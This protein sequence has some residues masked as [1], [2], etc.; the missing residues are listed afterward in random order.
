MAPL[1]SE[2]ISHFGV[3]IP[4]IYPLDISMT[5]SFDNISATLHIHLL[6][7]LL[8]CF[9]YPH[10]PALSPSL[11][12]SPSLSLPLSSSLSLSLPHPNWIQ[13]MNNLSLFF[14]LSLTCTT[15]LVQS[16]GEFLIGNHGQSSGHGKLSLFHS[17]P[18][19]FNQIGN[20]VIFDRFD[21]SIAGCVGKKKKQKKE[22]K[23]E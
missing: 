11:P 2:N 1:S 23:E 7:I 19:D 14:F 4:W 9:P 17:L 12:L 16:N 20:A 3:T 8:S 18:N 21:Y 13:I 6:F 22:K 5:I 10:P 15:N